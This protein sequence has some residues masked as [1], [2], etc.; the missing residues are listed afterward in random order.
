MDGSA[1]VSLTPEQQQQA[2]RAYDTFID[3]YT[4]TFHLEAGP[5][6]DRDDRERA[7]HAAIREGIEAILFPPA[8]GRHL[9]RDDNQPVTEDELLNGYG[10]SLDERIRRASVPHAL[11]RDLGMGGR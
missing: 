3:V 1:V 10:V 8:N 11:R 5:S 6:A 4:H 2:D 7:H 9:D